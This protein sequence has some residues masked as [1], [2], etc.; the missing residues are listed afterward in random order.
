[1]QT[2]SQPQRPIAIL[3]RGQYKQVFFLP[4][5][6]SQLRGTKSIDNKINFLNFLAETIETKYP[7]VAEF[8]EEIGHV[9]KAARGKK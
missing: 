2:A 9:E 8:V 1:M 3:K 4:I 7:E 6:I 5:L